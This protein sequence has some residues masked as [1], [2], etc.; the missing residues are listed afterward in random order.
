MA[1]AAHSPKFAKKVGIPKKVAKE[2]NVADQGTSQLRAAMRERASK[3]SPSEDRSTVDDPGLLERLLRSI[4][5][6]SR[7]PNEYPG[8]ADYPVA[9][10]IRG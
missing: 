3:K 8:G 4:A 5:I 9:I 2:F 6:Q 10:G 7:P 1:A